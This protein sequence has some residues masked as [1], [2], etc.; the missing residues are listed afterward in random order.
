MTVAKIQSGLRKTGVFPINFNAIDKAKFAPAQVTDSKENSWMLIELNSNLN[1]NCCPQ[2]ICL[3][4]IFFHCH[5]KLHMKLLSIFKLQFYRC[6]LAAAVA[7]DDDV[8]NRGG[9]GDAAEIQQP[10]QGADGVAAEPGV[11]DV[12]D[13]TG[14]EAAA[15]VDEHK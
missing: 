9:D 15:L 7:G 2:L 1:S 8:D 12:S 11:M 10:A 13:F 14:D 5:L 3:L 4:T 6:P